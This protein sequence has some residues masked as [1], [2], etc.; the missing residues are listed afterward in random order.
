[1]LTIEI[2][3]NYNRWGDEARQTI[4]TILA[5]MKLD[6]EGVINLIGCNAMTTSG[7]LT[8]YIRV[9]GRETEIAVSVATAIKKRFPNVRVEAAALLVVKP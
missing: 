7:V 4:I 8:S 5:D 1:M 6:H 9:Y 2:Y 3:P